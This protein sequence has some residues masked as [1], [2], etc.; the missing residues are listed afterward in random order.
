[1]WFGAWLIAATVIAFGRIALLAR[2]IGEWFR[3]SRR[4]PW[5]IGVVLC[6]AVLRTLVEAGTIAGVLL[7]PAAVPQ[8]RGWLERLALG[9]L[10]LG[11]PAWLLLRLLAA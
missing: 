9:A 1:M 10:Y 6:S 5:V 4:Q 3:R 8:L 7:Q 2:L 11:L